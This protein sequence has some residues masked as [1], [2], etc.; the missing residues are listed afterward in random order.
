MLH[1]SYGKCALFLVIQEKI[2]D[3][4]QAGVYKFPLRF[5]S[6]AMRAR[7]SPHDGQLYVS[8][9]KGWQTSGA[10]DGC[11][12]RV[13]Y[14]GKAVCVPKSL[15]VHE[16]GIRIGFTQPL[17]KELA[18]DLDR[19][20]VDGGAMELPVDKEVWVQGFL[21]PEPGQDPVKIFSATLLDNGREVFLKTDALG[22]VMQM[23]IHFDLESKDGDE[24]IGDVYNT[25][26]A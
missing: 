26:H 8:G 16:N 3:V 22:P 17:D 23:K 15:H 1:A 6:G 12:Q 5:E 25:I 24:L 13:R 2:G 18:E 7:F 20:T 21:G 10:N 4:D 19:W 14:T 11:L 9:L